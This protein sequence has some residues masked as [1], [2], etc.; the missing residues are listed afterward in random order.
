VNHRRGSPSSGPGISQHKRSMK[1]GAC[2]SDGPNRRRRQGCVCVSSGSTDVPVHDC[3]DAR[4]G[5][6]QGFRARHRGIGRLIPIIEP[7]PSGRSVTDPWA[8]AFHVTV[9]RRGDGA[10][11]E[12]RK[13]DGI[14]TQIACHR[15]GSLVVL[16]ANRVRLRHMAATLDCDACGLIMRVRHSDAYRDPDVGVAWAFVSYGGG[17]ADRT[18]R[19]VHGQ[20]LP[21]LSWLGLASPVRR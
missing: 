17:S 8:N 10:L 2:R 6:R 16:D 11:V 13:T 18:P 1:H 14:A 3:G 5:R 15:C 7:G 12:R 19:P 9:D 21:D 20:G 4:S